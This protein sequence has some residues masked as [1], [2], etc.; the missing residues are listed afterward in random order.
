MWVPATKVRIMS[1]QTLNNIL[2]AG[3]D[4]I[5]K[6]VL[7]EDESLHKIGITLAGHQKKI[8]TA[9]D[10]MK[11]STQSSHHN[12]L[13]TPEGSLPRCN[14]LPPNHSSSPC[15]PAPRFGTMT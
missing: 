13:L 2:T 5:D 1:V 12:L 7:M 3:W 9:I 8:K 11:S 4:T 6:V 15:L 10:F 14:T